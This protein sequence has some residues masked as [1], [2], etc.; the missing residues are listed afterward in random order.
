MSRH[1]VR[2]F[3]A[4]HFSLRPNSAPALMVRERRKGSGD[5]VC[6]RMRLILF[7]GSIRSPLQV[8]SP[9]PVQELDFY[10]S[11]PM[12]LRRSSLTSSLNDDD[13]DGFLEVLD[14]NMEVSR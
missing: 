4:G 2:S 6:F 1:R 5:P 8:S 7:H 10:D 12:F 3:N 9:P 11:S 13:D 14:D